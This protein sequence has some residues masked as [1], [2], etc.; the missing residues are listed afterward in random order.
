MPARIHQLNVSQGGV[1][2]RTVEAADVGPLGLAGDAQSDTQ[3][4]GGPL[5]AVCIYSLELIER[6]RAEGH[7]I[8]PG[9]LGENITIAGLDWPAVVPGSRLV[10][11]RGAEVEVAT[12]TKSCSGIRNAFTDLKFNRIWQDQHPGWSRVCCRVIRSGQLACGEGVR[13]IA[14]PIRTTYTG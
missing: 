14:A 2:K 13:L 8:F 9:A 5:R 7:P 12:Y 1:P 11:D 10:F 6:L 3:H 4:H